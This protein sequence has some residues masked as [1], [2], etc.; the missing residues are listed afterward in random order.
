MARNGGGGYIISPWT[1]NPLRKIPENSGFPAKEDGHARKRPIQGILELHSGEP[2]SW[3]FCLAHQNRTIAIASDFRVDGAKS[4]EI[5][6]KKGFFHFWAQTSQPE[7]AK[8]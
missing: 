3:A 8:R 2:E 1:K 7:I 5:L 4:P 6:Q